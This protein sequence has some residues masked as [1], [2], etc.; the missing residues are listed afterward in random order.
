MTSETSR[1]L[2]KFESYA[3]FETATFFRSKSKAAIERF[4]EIGRL[5]HPQFLPTPRRHVAPDWKAFQ[6]VPRTPFIFDGNRVD[7][8]DQ[9]HDA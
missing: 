2:P 1:A 5:G 6:S 4:H 3:V 8:I 9:T 7:A